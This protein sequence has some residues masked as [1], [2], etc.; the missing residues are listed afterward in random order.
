MTRKFGRTRGGMTVAVCSHCKT[1]GALKKR[2][3]GLETEHYYCSVCKG[4]KWPD[5]I[6]SYTYG[7]GVYQN[8]QG[9]TKYC[10]HNYRKNPEKETVH[11]AS[12]DK[13]RQAKRGL[14]RRETSLLRRLRD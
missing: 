3:A 13:A 8:A 2:D 7:I 11:R 1:E 9:E 5:E 4:E 12:L 14:S 6:E 10:H